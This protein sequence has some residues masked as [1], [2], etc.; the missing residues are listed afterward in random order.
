MSVSLCED[1]CQCEVE[2][3]DEDESEDECEYEGEGGSVQACHHPRHHPVLPR[4]HSVLPRQANASASSARVLCWKGCS[5]LSHG[6]VHT[7]PHPMSSALLCQHT[8]K[9]ALM[10]IVHTH[11]H[12]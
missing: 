2:G 1:E 11:A 8:L 5:P 9:R 6:R 4:H 10:Q 3:E 12:M 7:R